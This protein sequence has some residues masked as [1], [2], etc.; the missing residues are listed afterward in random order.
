M[1]AASIYEEDFLGGPKLT[2]MEEKDLERLLEEEMAYQPPQPRAPPKPEYVTEEKEILVLLPDW[3]KLKPF[4]R[5]RLSGANETSLLRLCAEINAKPAY[6][7]CKRVERSFAFKK[8]VMINSKKLEAFAKEEEI[9]LNSKDYVFTAF[10]PSNLSDD[11]RIDLSSKK[12]PQLKGSVNVLFDKAKKK[13]KRTGKEF[14]LRKFVKRFSHTEFLDSLS[15]YTDAA[16]VQMAHSKAKSLQAWTK[17]ISIKKKTEFKVKK[18]EAS[19]AILKARDNK[20]DNLMVQSSEEEKKEETPKLSVRR[21]NQKKKRVEISTRK[22]DNA[23]IRTAYARSKAHKAKIKKEKKQEK[24]EDKVKINTDPAPRTTPSKK[25]LPRNTG[26]TNLPSSDDI[27]RRVHNAKMRLRRLR[28][29]ESNA[30]KAQIS[31]NKKER[32]AR[33]RAQRKAKKIVIDTSTESLETLL[34]ADMNSPVLAALKALREDE[35]ASKNVMI[36]KMMK[37]LDNNDPAIT[38]LM[39]V[40][41]LLEC[42]SS[43]QVASASYLYL[44]SWGLRSCRKLMLSLAAGTICA[45]STHALLMSIRKWREANNYTTESE[46]ETKTQSHKNYEFDPEKKI[47]EE[48]KE[49]FPGFSPSRIFDKMLSWGGRF[50]TS[51]V[52]L[53]LKKFILSLV[54]FGMFGR[55]DSDVIQKIIGKAKKCSILECVQDVLHSLAQ[56]I[57]S[58]EMLVRGYP[59]ESCFFSKD[60]LSL[61]IVKAREWVDNIPLVVQGIPPPGK[62]H[63]KAHVTE[64]KEILNFLTVASEKVSPLGPNYMETHDALRRMQIAL[65]MLRS[66]LLSRGRPT[67]LAICIVGPPGIGKSTLITM[68]SFLYCVIAGHAWTPEVIFHRTPSEQFWEGFDPEIHHIVHISEIG[69]KSDK[70]MEKGDPAIAE[71]TSVIDSQPYAVPMA[72]EKKGKSFCLAE[73]IIIDTN[74][75]DMGLSIIQ[76]N[77]TAFQRRFL[78]I[79]PIVKEQYRMAGSNMLDPKRGDPSN[80]LDKWTYTVCKKR[81]KGKNKQIDTIPVFSAYDVKEFAKKFGEYVREYIA[82]ETNVQT[83]INEQLPFLAQHAVVPDEMKGSDGPEVRI[84][85][86]P[87]DPPESE[88]EKCESESS[89]EEVDAYDYLFNSPYSSE[90]GNAFNSL[91]EYVIYT[92][93]RSFSPEV[94]S[95]SLM[96]EISIQKNFVYEA[97]RRYCAA[98]ST[99]TGMVY[100][101]VSSGLSYACSAVDLYLHRRDKYL[102]LDPNMWVVVLSTLLALMVTGDARWLMLLMVIIFTR[103]PE[104]ILRFKDKL[105]QF[106]KSKSEFKLAWKTARN[107]LS[108]VTEDIL[109]LPWHVHILSM[110][111]LAAGTIATYKMFTSFIQ[112][113]QNFESEA[114]TL[115]REVNNDIDE[116]AGVAPLK[117]RNRIVPDS[118]NVIIGNV[119]IHTSG[120]NSLYKKVMRNVKKA[121]VKSI[122]LGVE[123]ATHI[124]GISNNVALINT[125]AL[126]GQDEVIISVKLTDTPTSPWRESHVTEKD[127]MHLGN[128][129]SLVLLS[130]FQFADILTH[131]VRLPQ[132]KNA[133]GLYKGDA[134][135]V[136]HETLPLYV[137]DPRCPVTLQDYWT[138]KS[139]HSGGD[140]GNPLIVETQGGSSIVGFH[141]AGGDHCDTVVVASFPDKLREKVEELIASSGLLRVTSESRLRCEF[142][143]SINNKSAIF[144]ED[145]SN[146]KILGTVNEPILMNHKSKLK[147]TP[148]YQHIHEVLFDQMDFIAEETFGPPHLKPFKGKGGEWT[149]PYN[150]AYRKMNS[151]KGR[152]NRRTLRKVI[153]LIS[154]KWIARMKK[155]GVTKLHPLTLEEAINGAKE[156]YYARSIDMSKGA[157]YGFHGKKKSHFD[158]ILEGL[159]EPS[160]SLMKKVIARKKRYLD[161]KGEP[162]I[163]TGMPKDEPRERRK[164]EL[165]KTRLFYAGMLDSLVVARQYLAPFYTLMSQYRLDFGCAL[166]VDPHREAKG[167]MDHL[168]YFNK[169]QYGKELMIEGDYSGYDVNMCP[170]ITWAAFTIISII[171]KAMGY[172]EDAMKI[173]NG[174]LSDFMHPYILIL[175]D[176]IMVLITPS[177]KYGTAEDN[178]VKGV[179][180]IVYIFISHPNGKDKDPFICVRILVY[181][182]DMECA[183]RP[184]CKWFDSFYFSKACKEELGLTF[185]SA[186]KG[187]HSQRFVDL[188]AAS[189]LRRSFRVRNGVF[190]MPLTMNSA[191]KTIGWIIPSRFT[192]EK[193]QMLNAFNSFLR[194]V[195][196]TGSKTQ[197]EGVRQW[198]IQVFQE[199]YLIDDPPLQT[200]HEI[201][202]SLF[203]DVDFT[204]E[205]MTVTAEEQYDIEELLNNLMSNGFNLDALYREKA[206]VVNTVANL[207]IAHIEGL[208][209]SH[210]PSILNWPADFKYYLRG[211]IVKMKDE[212]LLMEGKAP[213]NMDQLEHL[214][215]SEIVSLSRY[216]TDPTYKSHCEACMNFRGKRDGL[217]L[218]IATLSRALLRHNAFSTESAEGYLKPDAGMTEMKTENLGDMTGGSLDLMSATP[219]RNVDVGQ[220]VPLDIRNFLSR[221]VRIASYANSPGV[222]LDESINPWDAY[223]SQPSV[224]AKLRNTAYLR[225]DMHIRIAVSGMPFHY[226]RYLYSYLPFPNRNEP[227]T[228]L[229]G[230]A[231]SGSDFAKLVYLSQSPYAR[232]GDVVANE[233]VEMIVPYLS[234]QPVIRLFNDSTSALAAVSS[235]DDAQNLGTLYLK[236]INTLD[237]TNATSTPV[238]IAL[239]AWMENVEFGS[240]TATHLEVTTESDERIVGPISSATKSLSE[241]AWKLQNVP[242]I[243]SYAKASGRVMEG[244]SDIASALGWSY[245]TLIDDPMRMK[246]EPFQNAATSIGMD[247]GKRIVLDP[248]QELSVDPRPSGTEEDELVISNIVKRESLLYTF[249]WQASATSL[250]GPI[251]ILA[252]TP[253]I[254]PSMANG[255]APG[256]KQWIVHTPL[257]FAASPFYFWRGEITYRVEFVCSMYHRGKMI[258]GYEPNIRQHTLIDT[259]LDTNKNYITTVDLQETRCIEFTVKWANARP[260]LE[261]GPLDE[262]VSPGIVGI[263][264]FNQFGRSNGYVYFTP[265]TKLQSPDSGDIGVNIYIRSHDM[266]FNALDMARMPTEFTAESTLSPCEE[267]NSIILNPTSA[268][269]DGINEIYF[270]EEPLSF[271]SYLR[272]F[273]IS[274]AEDFSKTTALKKFLFG[275]MRVVPFVYPNYGEATQPEANQPNLLSHLRYCFLSIKG[276]FRKRILIHDLEPSP[277]AP[278]IISLEYQDAM[279]NSVVSEASG[280]GILNQTGGVMFVPQ[281]NTG[282]EFEIPWYSTNTWGFS[283]TLD[284]FPSDSLINRKSMYRYLLRYA[285][286]G[287]ARVIGLREYTAIAED[288]SLSNFIAAPPAIVYTVP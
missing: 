26:N 84:D 267:S 11:D 217:K 30:R 15:D 167:L 252:V 19:Q 50:F 78:Y 103:V 218:S 165:G 171:L 155:R 270:G 98:G 12:A 250:S 182:D 58:G 63:I 277:N 35:K 39:F 257:S 149:S 138:F 43:T 27:A 197:F 207:L 276:G 20:L 119:P 239:Y 44:S 56:L 104:R 173:V 42:R 152:A 2:E 36:E 96:K 287:S 151:C 145:M 193:D 118:W 224:R 153:K 97:G 286:G 102:F 163:F 261:C 14:T 219:S 186:A 121:K 232:T 243:G 126:L 254:A 37:S 73:L 246:N 179:V 18:K 23:M 47:E 34:D 175:G 216:G 192:T 76:K 168:S 157:G 132:I 210:L 183:V 225:G 160:E 272:R 154:K 166:G 79:F 279:A 16:K 136:T 242:I 127:M 255:V 273:A 86:V 259:V 266:H 24:A 116:K 80:F 110:V 245:P 233:P 288:F 203:P 236:S 65:P 67:P 227:W 142:R 231:I 22:R 111:T 113:K 263:D 131:C 199:T 198:G 235:F 174:L 60:P 54:S 189:F 124:C 215:R 85:Q 106:K 68:I 87:N 209:I 4:D 64:G 169:G 129:C 9:L 159:F 161:G 180:I 125:H 94:L 38:L 262:A 69:S 278:A 200:H 49:I 1:S 146:I 208:E 164:I 241:A 187:E 268:S 6:K 74:E 107:N 191:E 229:Q 114:S 108:N 170:D 238:S 143:E 7:R 66:Q 5:K 141:A 137:K 100:P 172:T 285:L 223:L 140:C 269:L 46:I 247:T 188:F 177:G 185:T 214:S 51:D 93:H 226:G 211:E 139:P 92:S 213:D 258:I 109:V 253:L 61:Y 29:E 45:A 134:C 89:Y 256:S 283:Q 264:A 230:L 59:I 41:N 205:S 150:L 195:F 228:Y 48:T 40:A 32:R 57:R 156:D 28:K 122:T 280:I 190:V 144:Y 271:R 133:D 55:E 158:E 81:P 10:L 53:S 181:G 176:L 281:T 77:P 117:A 17:E 52:Y 260:W 206:V 90:S 13:A 33:K 75:E 120:M 130:S 194:E 91:V 184:D 135:A 222:A 220:K 88:E 71:L 112:N 178:S 3:N 282:V 162:I 148:F 221:P 204:A 196:L 115:Q 25:A 240:P 83:K 105:D 237:S 275:D 128:D 72:F 202:D 123:R 251:T 284:Y 31:V 244:V 249:T 82:V 70:V 62:I 274:H 8:Q 21:M 212:L 101:V 234:P 99:L 248:K 95:K 201:N 147:K 265:L